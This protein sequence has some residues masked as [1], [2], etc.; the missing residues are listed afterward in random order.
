METL[1]DDQRKQYKNE[2]NSYSGC[3]TPIQEEVFNATE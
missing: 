1:T 2:Q 3:I